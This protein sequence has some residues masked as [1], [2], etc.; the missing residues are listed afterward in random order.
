[1]KKVL[2]ILSIVSILA[3]CKKD[4]PP[5]VEDLTPFLKF[6]AEGKDL[7]FGPGLG[8]QLNYAEDKGHTAMLTIYS[9]DPKPRISWLI[10]L[11][12]IKIGSYNLDGSSHQFQ[13]SVFHE[14]LN[15]TTT[16]FVGPETKPLGFNS[17]VVFKI[18]K[19]DSGFLGGNFKGTIV[20]NWELPGPKEVLIEGSFLV[21]V[22]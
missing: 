12:E 14:E 6:K 10:A 11:P 16:Y 9:L 1:M 20:K 22:K 21:K 18:T 13:I 19:Y 17:K 5:K 3:A 7:P 8:N 4:V 2:F 15:Q